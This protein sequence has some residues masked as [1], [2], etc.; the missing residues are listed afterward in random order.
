MGKGAAAALSILA[1]FLAGVWLYGWFQQP[2]PEVA[3]QIPTRAQIDSCVAQPDS[4]RVNHPRL[5]R[6]LFSGA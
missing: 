6:D 1:A 2:P 5:Y 4:C 3:P